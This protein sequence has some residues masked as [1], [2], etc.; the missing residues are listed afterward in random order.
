MGHYAKV[1]DGIVTEVIVAK[2]DYIQTRDDKDEWIK[3]SYNTRGGRHYES[4]IGDTFS[5][6]QAKALRWN[7]AGVGYNY[8]KDADAFYSQKPFD[9]WILD[10]GT[11]Q[12]RAPSAML[13]G[14]CWWD[15]DNKKWQEVTQEADLSN[16]PTDGD[17]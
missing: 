3:T 1:K 8:D 14:P 2:W 7:F 11:W 10:K 17:D 13:E 16:P 6:N 12:W 4:N 5:D 15:E 9:S